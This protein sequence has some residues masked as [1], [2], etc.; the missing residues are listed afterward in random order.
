[1][2]YF[3][4]VIAA[5]ALAMLVLVCGYRFLFEDITTEEDLSVMAKYGDCG[6]EVIE[7]QKRLS[8]LGYY[9][10]AFNGSFDLKTAEAVKAFQEENG[11]HISGCAN[12]ETLAALGM[13]PLREELI[14]YERIQFLARV[15]D[16]ICPDSPY[17][18][19]VALAGVLLKR[20]TENVGS[21]SL[22]TE[23]FGDPA[24]R[25]AYLARFHEDPSEASLRAVGDA[26][27]GLSPCPDAMYFYRSDSE[28]LFLK[29][30]PI[31]YRNSGY[32]FA[33]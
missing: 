11:L 5:S 7:L 25:D 26:L 22:A 31:V 1:V 15:I 13:N 29:R 16:A 24:L 30:R 12:M 21:G 20:C 32:I 9:D 2:R 3:F 18:V 28:D 6:D 19:R 14:A 17:P 10:G 4:R 8:R 23:V 27:A 33:S